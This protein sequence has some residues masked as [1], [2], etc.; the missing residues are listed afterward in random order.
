[1]DVP[2]YYTGLNAHARGQRRHP[3]GRMQDNK[4]SFLTSGTILMK[5]KIPREYKMKENPIC[6]ISPYVS[7]YLPNIFILAFGYDT[8]FVITKPAMDYPNHN[9]KT[10]NRT[11][12][13][14]CIPVLI[15]DKGL[16]RH[17][18]DK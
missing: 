11:V 8:D 10:S 16:S 14:E 7:G 3:E 12:K 5:N 18:T 6:G 2:I 15:L 4:S 17:M 1:M 13:L 9:V